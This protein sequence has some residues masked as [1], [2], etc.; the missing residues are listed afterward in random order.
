MNLQRV[1]YVVLDEADRM[2]DM[3]FALQIDRIIGNARPDRQTLLFSA[4]FPAP[5]EKLARSVLTKPVQIIAGGISVV[6]NTIDQHVEVVTTDNKMT[7]LCEL[8]RQYLD[9][10]QVLVFVDTQE[11][12]NNLFKEL[13]KQSLPCATLHGGMGQDDRDSTISDFKSGNVSLLIATSVA[14]RGLDVKDL[15]C[16]INYE[17]PNHYEDYVHRVGRCGRAGNAGTAYT[18]IT[19]EEEKFAPDLVKALEKAGQE[20][21][22]DVLCMANA[23]NAKRKAGELSTKDYR[24][25]GFK[26]GKGIALDA[27]SMAKEESKKRT[28]RKAAMRAA[29]VDGDADDEEEDGDAVKATGG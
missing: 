23:Y 1:T 10:G 18:F 6:S 11:A 14:A 15:I 5:V 8:L 13:M 12:A 17:V 2:F 25:S 28:G 3:G 16:V 24:T 21:P 9:E 22:D 4:T 19:P 26:S 29:G 27:E 20:P 7:R